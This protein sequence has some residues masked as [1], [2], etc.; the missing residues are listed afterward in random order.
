MK[1]YSIMIVVLYTTSALHCSSPNQQ[2]MDES[3]HDINAYNSSG[4]T[5]LHDAAI[6]EN[7]DEMERILQTPG[8]YIDAQNS[9]QITALCV[10]AAKNNFALTE[11]LVQHGAN[12]YLPKKEK[13]KRPYKITRSNQIKDLLQDH[14]KTLPKDEDS[15]DDGNL[16]DSS[17]DSDHDIYGA[18]KQHLNQMKSNAPFT[19]C[20]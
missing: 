2:A 6:T 11:L 15:Q 1:K 9:K 16:S 3:C 13:S 7:F 20:T 4:N 18:Y 10:T 12:P 8:V 5:Q 14:I 17:C 19:G